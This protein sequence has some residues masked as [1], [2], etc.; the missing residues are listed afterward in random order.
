PEFSLGLWDEFGTTPFVA[1]DTWVE[2]YLSPYG[3]EAGIIYTI[4]WGDGSALRTVADGA[5]PE[6][7]TYTND[8]SYLVSVTATDDDGDV[9]NQI[10]T[11]T[12]ET[13]A[14]EIALMV[15]PTAIAGDTVQADIQLLGGDEAIAYSLDWG[16]GSEPVFI[17]PGMAVPSHS[18]TQI[19]IYTVTLTALDDDGDVV[20]ITQD[21]TA[22][23]VPIIEDQGF[24]IAESSINGTIV[25][26]LSATDPDGEV[27]SFSLTSLV[28]PDGD[29]NAAFR[30]E[31]HQLVVNDSDDLDFEVSSI[32]GVN[33]EVSDGTLMATATM[34]VDVTDINE[35]PEFSSSD[36]FTATENT[37]AVA[38]VTAIDPENTA[39]TFSL[40]SSPDQALFDLDASTGSLSFNS[41]PDFEAPLDSNGDN[42]YQLQLQAT[43]G[44]NFITQ[45][46]TVTV[47]D[48][49]ETDAADNLDPVSQSSPDPVTQSSPDPVIQDNQS[50]AT[51]D[52]LDPVIQDNQEPING[53]SQG[54]RLIG[55]VTDDIIS[56]GGGKDVLRGQAGNDDL[57]GGNGRDHLLGGNGEDTLS[58][59]AGNDRLKGQ[60]GDDI[61][62]GGK[63]ADLLMG[64]RGNDRLDG[65]SGRDRYVGGK[66]ADTFVLNLGEG[67][68]IIR[69]FRPSQGDTIA[70]ANGLRFSDLTIE[71][72]GNKGARIFVGEELL[73]RVQSTGFDAINT[74]DA[75]STI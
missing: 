53:S 33:V 11:I 50:S 54:D 49:E 72:F 21:I 24:A 69:D 13:V 9:F 41:P 38:T 18:Y 36:S 28:D 52:N 40:S 57:S 59:D 37:L 39:L 10:Q 22:S 8:G 55:T 2:L 19:G 63:G 61:L 46:V 3:N 14:P 34:T 15:S 75:F 67:V 35:A 12:V 58:G 29:G 43:D 56:G 73:A 7:H 74:A 5:I 47:T 16:D 68:D 32:L 26:T 62:L 6:R 48:I 70:L 64:G 65:G 42:V 45:D 23:N 44:V 4:D 27:L 25:G 30:L 71:R 1:E 20:S 17:E 51:E 60:A 66:G 31:G